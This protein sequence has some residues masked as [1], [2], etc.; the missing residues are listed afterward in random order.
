ME[1]E[2][3]LHIRIFELFGHIVQIV[4]AQLEKSWLRTR[5]STRDLAW[6][7]KKI[8]TGLQLKITLPS[9]VSP[10]STVESCS[11]IT[12]RCGRT[13]KSL[14]QVL[15]VAYLTQSIINLL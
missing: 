14:I 11:D 3:Y 4:P 15:N 10:E 1:T 5:L 8:I 12:K 7:Y 9:I 2:R 6:A 13:F